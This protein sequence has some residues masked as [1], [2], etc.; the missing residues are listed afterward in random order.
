MS[1]QKTYLFVSS[2]LFS[3]HH[4]ENI[5][6]RV[7]PV[8]KHEK[9]PFFTE[10]LI[11]NTGRP[12]EVR[13]DNGYPNV[14]H[15]RENDIFRLYYSTFITDEESRCRPLAERPSAA[16]IPTSRRVVATCYAESKDG[17][18]WTKPSLGKVVWNGSSD[19]N[20]LMAQTHGAGIFLDDQEPDPKKRYKM[21]TRIDLGSGHVMA[22]C[23]S[24]DGLNFT[25]PIEIRGLGPQADT[26][27][28]VFRDR[29]SGRFVLITR[30][31]KDGV[32]IAAKSVSDNFIDW[33]IP[34]EIL[35]GF[36]PEWQVYSMPV[37]Q[38][39]DLYLGLPS[40]YREGDRTMPDFDKVDV[41]LAF[42]RDLDRFDFTAGGDPII[43]RGEGSYPDGAFDA[44][45]VYASAPI[46]TDDRILIY[47]VGG[48]GLHTGF[49]EGSLA[50]GYLERDKYA[51]L[52]PRDSSTSGIVVTRPFKMLGGEVRLLTEIEDGGSI[53]Y[54]LYD[55]RTSTAVD[56]FTANDVTPI[57]ESGWV[58]LAFNAD[59][60]EYPVEPVSIR[61]TLRG[62]RV[63]GIQGDLWLRTR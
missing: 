19:N 55:P 44:G 13:Y 24:E 1:M 53:E 40:M 52:E 54:E 31:W 46:F 23:Y 27:N 57:T 25:D 49:R 9:S 28:V 36:G 20:I 48:N 18:H 59:P 16:Y 14:I 22:V 47:Y 62:A 42:S 5:Q 45:C 51:F 10:A 26:H 12:W 32:R 60:S 30:I 34:V 3:W 50:L 41:S 11:S 29:D 39:A 63:F 58:S 4:M 43:P 35:R 33:S 7:R 15:D 2:D 56:G 61:M 17:I 38:E 6:W 37:F 8:L 21:L